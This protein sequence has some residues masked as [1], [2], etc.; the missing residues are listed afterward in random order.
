MAVVRDLGKSTS[1]SL[2]YEAYGL[3]EDYSQIIT[4]ISPDKTP[5]L[6]GLAEDS[7]AVSTGF[8][9]TTEALRPP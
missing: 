1:Q 3:A 8:S 9:W 7:D 4:N 5:F 6:S 2:T